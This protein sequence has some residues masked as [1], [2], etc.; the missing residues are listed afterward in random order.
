[1]MLVEETSV[2]PGALPVAAFKEHLRLGSG[3][4]EDSLQDGLLESFLQ[5]AMSAVEARTCKVLIERAYAWTLYGWRDGAAQALPV[6]PVS[7]VTDIGLTDAQGSEV[8][9]AASAY[10]LVKDTHHPRVRG[11][12]NSLP[13]V[14][15]NGSVTL[16]FVAGFGAA[17][18]DVPADLQQA[19]F[20]LAAHF[21]EFRQETT[22]SEGC[23]PFGV[24]SLLERY[25]PL[26]MGLGAVQ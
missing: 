25:R 26:R 7:A 10:Q 21:Y 6:A 11:V 17:W 15:E 13:Q 18:S 20:L 3:F 9:V 22:L 2:P 8:V 4:T 19:V 14:P 12:S 16:R 23:M 1:M 5:A 24:T